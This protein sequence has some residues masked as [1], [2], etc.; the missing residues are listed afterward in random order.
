MRISW[1][2]KFNA[3]PMIVDLFFYCCFLKRNI[4]HQLWCVYM[5]YSHSFHVQFRGL[6]TILIGNREQSERISSQNQRYLINEHEAKIVVE[7]YH[8]NSIFEWAFGNWYKFSTNLLPLSPTSTLDFWTTTMKSNSCNPFLVV[9]LIF[10]AS[11]Y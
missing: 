4:Y 2:W 5:A 9:S 6:Q 1:K 8:Y 10:I 3:Y 7:K 11:N